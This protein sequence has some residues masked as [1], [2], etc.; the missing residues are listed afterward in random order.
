MFGARGYLRQ[1]RTDAVVVVVLIAVQVL[2]LVYDV[3][4]TPVIAFAYLAVP[5]VLS[6]G[7]GRPRVTGLLA[8]IGALFALVS[9]LDNDYFSSSN[10]ILQFTLMILVS[11]VA[12]LLSVAVERS[13]R[14]RTVLLDRLSAAM[15]SELEAHAFLQP[16]YDASGAIRDFT[17]VD[18]NPVA[19]EYFGRPRSALVGKGLVELFPDFADHP[20]LKAYVELATSNKPLVLQEMRIDSVVSGAERYIDL[21]GVAVGN[22][23]SLSWHDVT[24]RVQDQQRLAESEH[25]LR[26]LLEN[27]S[28]VVWE[29]TNDG[30]ISWVSPQVSTMLG[31]TPE[32]LAGRPFLELVNQH[33]VP[34][35]RALQGDVLEGHPA[36]FEVRVRRRDGGYR[37]MSIIANPVFDDHGTVIGR[38]G[39]WRDVTDE[40]RT[41]NELQSSEA[42]FRVL[43]TQVS[44]VIVQTT[45]DGRIVW[46]SPSAS[47]TLGWK[48][49]AL[50]GTRMSELGH[51][52]DRSAMAALLIDGHDRASATA[53]VRIRLGDG[54]YRWMDAASDQ[55]TGD[56]RGRAI[57]LR[58]AEKQV[59]ATEELQRLVATD[60]LTGL[61]NWREARNQIEDLS[62]RLS[63][64][65]RNAL[66]VIDLDHFKDIN[67]TYGHLAGDTVLRT[68]AEVVERSIRSTDFA[69]RTGGD[70][71]L[72]ILTGIDSLAEAVKVA[73]KIRR[74][75]AEPIEVAP[76]RLVTTTLSIGVAFG[77][78]GENP[79]SL[80]QRADSALY[81]AKETGRD[82]VVAA[83]PDAVL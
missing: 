20:L 79:D 68:V 21:H 28:D 45:D 14:Q 80:F 29:G 64:G 6:V 25:K 19:C 71:L 60:A 3:L 52:E 16:V 81:K 50:V 7:M 74:G 57:R 23:I 26:A 46:A 18:V 76:G 62:S 58:D 33:D 55:L 12:V 72:V 22:Q 9:A 31:W 63:A 13:R 11:L 61:A 51:P 47:R 66:L 65:H 48:P 83:Q 24:D 30:I 54:S 39:G 4:Q 53:T 78:A 34:R 49:E 2:I 38:T 75:A 32:E 27:S 10:G 15:E 67:D 36:R 59:V 42:R 70:E 73:E 8:G 41:R 35:I 40:V 1:G 44:D 43:A 56:L 77:G 17:Y 37:W 69:A 5:P 82:H